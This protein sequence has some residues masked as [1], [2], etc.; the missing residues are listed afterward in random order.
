M[1]LHD[2]LQQTISQSSS[3]PQTRRFRARFSPSLTFGRHFGRPAWDARLASVL[4]LFYNDRGTI[5]I[6]FTVRPES[7]R[8]HGGQ[9]SLPGGMQ[10]A[11][12]SSQDAAVREFREE[13]GCSSDRL[14]ILGQLSPIYVYNSN[15]YVT[16]WVAWSDDA[17]CFTPNPAEVETAFSIPATELIRQENY[18]A[19]TVTRGAISFQAPAIRWQ[20]FRIWGATSV[21]LGELISMLEGYKTPRSK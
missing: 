9:V 18:E 3:N 14:Q 16:P 10:E 20:G 4:V 13:L 2:Y 11:G 8:E 1:N 12:E 21:I 19:F 6:P 15:F 5:S 7:L 17:L